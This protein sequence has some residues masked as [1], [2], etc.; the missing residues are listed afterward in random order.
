MPSTPST[1][2]SRL[3][4][5]DVLAGLAMLAISAAVWQQVLP[6]DVGTLSYFGPGFLPRFLAVILTVISLAL[7][8]MGLFAR[9]AETLVLKVRGPVFVALGVL[10]FAVTIRGLAIG[11]LEIPQLGLLLAGPVTVVVAGY[12]TR[13][14]RWRELL[15]LGLALTALSTLVFSDFL[16]TTLPIFPEGIERTLP[17]AWREWP[18]RAMCLLYL[19]LA[20]AI[21]LPLI[22]A[23]RTA[24]PSEPA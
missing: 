24:R 7:I 22:R 18:K 4:R 16:S 6:L 23:A 11:A 19:A 21:A 14:A 13:E 3:K 5:V 8:A 10:F 9:E 17:S 15:A 20:A 2:R 1:V 12:G